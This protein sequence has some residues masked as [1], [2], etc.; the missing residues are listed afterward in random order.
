MLR[1]DIEFLYEIGTLRNVER[2][3]RQVLGPGVATV[4]DHTV[5]T[6]FLAFLL[7]RMEGEKDEARV[8]K[9][10][11]VHDLTEARTGDTN[12]VHAVYT[13]RDELKAAK[14]LFADTLF[15]DFSSEILRE[16]KERKSC[17][18]R[19]V[20]DADNLD[21]ELELSELKARGSDTARKMQKTR[22]ARLLKALYT[23][24]AK[25]LLREFPRVV[26][27]S[28]FLSSNKWVKIKDAGK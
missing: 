9:M 12:A 10:A 2:T 21:V 18:S 6:V 16:Y 5:R 25:K 22:R 3:W 20:K 4:L 7:A 14:D 1:R 8:M 19:I 28:W 15:Q 27:A 23:K 17:V 26:P 24:S 11:L 13:T